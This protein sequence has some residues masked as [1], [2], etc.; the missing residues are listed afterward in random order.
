MTKSKIIR[1]NGHDFIPVT[2]RSLRNHEF[3][4]EKVA[5]ICKKCKTNAQA[6]QFLMKNGTTGWAGWSKN[7]HCGVC[8]AREIMES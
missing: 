3:M 5:M 2:H 7:D 1:H 8:I 4:G 6:I